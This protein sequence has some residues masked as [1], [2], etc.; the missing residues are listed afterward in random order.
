M[1]HLEHPQPC[2]TSPR[3][4]RTAAPSPDGGSHTRPVANTRAFSLIELLAAMAVLG[5]LVAVLFTALRLTSDLTT[6][7]ANQIEVSQVG[8]AVLQQIAEDI[9]QAVNLS[10]TVNM[11]LANAGS[12]SLPDLGYVVG[13]ITNSTLYFLTANSG[14]SGG[15]SQIGVGYCITNSFSIAGI[16]TWQLSRA[17]DVS[18]D[19]V[20]CSNDW[21]T[22]SCCTTCV[23]WRAFSEN[24]IGIA[25]QFYTNAT[26]SVCWWP[27]NGASCSPPTPLSS[28]L[29][30]SVDVTL[31]AIDTAAYHRAL[32][33]GADF[34]GII[35]NWVHKYETRVFLPQSSQN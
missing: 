11:Y 5:I 1:Y 35:T 28:A 31:W 23:N 2:P 15:G 22:T 18:V 30:Q 6:R 29:P 3:S 21:W 16:P 9:E 32:A 26:D 14:G 34:V 7:S 4:H 8:R 17:D 33:P 10:P 19:T 13:G 24:I 20:T 12:L 27:P 25:F